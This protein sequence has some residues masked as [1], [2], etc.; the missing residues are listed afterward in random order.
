M[1]TCQVAIEE[2]PHGTPSFV[3]IRVLTPIANAMP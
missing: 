2:I 3:T 1:T